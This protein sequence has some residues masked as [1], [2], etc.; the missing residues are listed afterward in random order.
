MNIFKSILCGLAIASLVS[1]CGSVSGTSGASAPAAVNTISPGG[2]WQGTDGNNNLPI[3]GVITEDGAFTF[4]ESNGVVYAGTITMSGETFTGTFQ[5]YTT[6]ASTP[7]WDGTTHA[8]GSVSGTVVQQ[9]VLTVSIVLTTDLGA[10]SYD[11][12]RLTFDTLYN[13]G[14]SL[15]KVAGN[16]QDESGT[17]YSIDAKGMVFGQSVTTGC[18]VNGQVSVVNA[19]YDVYNVTVTIANCTALYSSENGSTLSGLAVLDSTVNPVQAAVIVTGAD[20]SA[21]IGLILNLSRT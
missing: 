12:V 3:E 8:T 9:S 15:T 18:V 5:G 17:V 7:F 6:D 14:A 21:K 4:T 19:A 20:G 11:K 2:I 1:A 13:A 10:T 16:Y